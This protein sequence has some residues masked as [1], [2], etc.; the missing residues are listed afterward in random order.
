LGVLPEAKLQACLSKLHNSHAGGGHAAKSE[1][2]ALR[3]NYRCPF[4]SMNHLIEGKLPE[5]SFAYANSI[6]ALPAA[7]MPPNFKHFQLVIEFLA[8]SLYQV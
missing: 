3:D 6:E 4:G 7:S 5:I 2:V 8:Y 1:F